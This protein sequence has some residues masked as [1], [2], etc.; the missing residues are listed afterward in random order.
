[1][2]RPHVASVHVDT[3]AR[4]DAAQHVMD[5]LTHRTMCVAKRP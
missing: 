4:Q 1:M 3:W 5:H 2:Q